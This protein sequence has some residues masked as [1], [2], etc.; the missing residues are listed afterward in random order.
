MR[1]FDKTFWW[2]FLMRN[3]DET[4]WWDILMKHY[5]ETY[6]LSLKNFDDLSWPLMTFD[7]LWYS[8]DVNG[9]ALWL[10]LVLKATLLFGG[11]VEVLFWPDKTQL[12]RNDLGWRHLRLQRGKEGLGEVA[13]QSCWLVCYKRGYLVCLFLVKVNLISYRP[14]ASR[15]RPVFDNLTEIAELLWLA[16]GY[17]NM[18]KHLK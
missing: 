8:D 7:D 12:E 17:R 15:R 14:K 2:D 1:H 4:F 5:D 3:F 10:S 9:M 13:P 16:V 18:Q 6:R 11:E